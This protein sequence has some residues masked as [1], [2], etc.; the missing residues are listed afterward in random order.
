MTQLKKKLSQLGDVS[1]LL[2]AQ[3]DP[4][5]NTGVV[6]SKATLDRHA[7][8]LQSRMQE[9]YAQL[10]ST[11]DEHSKFAEKYHVIDM[12]LKSLPTEES[13]LSAV[14]IPLIQQ[15][16]LAAKETQE[17]IEKMQP[18]MGR[19]NEMGGE[20]ALSDEDAN[21]LAELNERW[22]T[23]CADKDKER[24]E[25]EQRLAELEKFNEQCEQ[26][27]E[28]VTGVETDLQLTPACSYETLLE[29][30]Q[31]IEVIYQTLFY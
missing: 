6:D 25:L 17:K 8:N 9:H 21:K 31:K 26:W 15:S 27:N 18:E 16:I 30:Q 24:K 19:L 20:L 14:D 23:T 28:F 1:G 5:A 22:K 29:E 2:S 12:F 3:L 7:D 4:V 11:M 13:R 10:T